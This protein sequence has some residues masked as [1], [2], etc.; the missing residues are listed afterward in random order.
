MEFAALTNKERLIIVFVKYRDT[1]LVLKRS[2]KVSYYKNLWD[3]LRFESSESNLR[4]VIESEVCN[5]LTLEPDQIKDVI[6]E[7]AYKFEDT[8]KVYYL[9]KVTHPFLEVSWEYDAY[10]WIQFRSIS[11]YETVPN[12]KEELEKVKNY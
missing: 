11:T 7:G 10:E 12:L 1:F 8:E 4:Q 9:V 3:T 6:R 2:D 5:A